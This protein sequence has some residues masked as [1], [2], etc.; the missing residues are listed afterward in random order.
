MIK[1]LIFISMILSFSIF[2]NEKPKEAKMN[3]KAKIIEPIKVE[4]GDME[5]GTIV[6]GGKNY[7]ATAPV[8]IKSKPYDRIKV[9][10]SSG[11]KPSGYTNGIYL[12]NELQNKKIFV[13][14]SSVGDY[15]SGNVFDINNAPLTQSVLGKLNLRIK[16]RLDVPKEQLSGLYSGKLNF[17]VR[18]N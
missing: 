11:T 5:F 16:G 8:E 7:I 2:A 9:T 14:L 12:Y 3:I 10:V 15:P 1:K 17:K 6:A 13:I 18:Y 4:T